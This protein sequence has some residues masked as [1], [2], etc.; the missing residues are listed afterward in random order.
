MDFSLARHWS[1][2][3]MLLAIDIVIHLYKSEVGLIINV[4]LNLGLGN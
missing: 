1:A 2:I 4:V 3:Y